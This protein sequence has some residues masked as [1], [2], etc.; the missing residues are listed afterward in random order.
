VLKAIEWVIPAL[1]I[2]DSRIAGW[3][4]RIGDTI[5]DN[6]SSARFVLGTAKTDP[7]DLDLRLAQMVF[8]RN[9]VTVDSGTGAA[10]LGHPV[11]SAAWL[12]GT[13]ERAGAPLRAGDVVLTGALHKMYEINAGDT[14]EAEFD[15]LGNVSVHF[16]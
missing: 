12:A 10:A 9:G 5:A 11:A 15:L 7:K 3:R 2:V 8:F 1:E 13:L 14:F 6:A 4:I 16:V